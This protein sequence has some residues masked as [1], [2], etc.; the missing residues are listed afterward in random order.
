[1]DKT[2]KFIRRHKKEKTFD[3]IEGCQ[4]DYGDGIGALYLKCDKSVGSIWRLLWASAENDINKICLLSYERS[5]HEANQHQSK[6]DIVREKDWVEGSDFQNRMAKSRAI[7]RVKEA[8][9]LTTKKS[10]VKATIILSDLVSNLTRSP[11]FD[12][13]DILTEE[14]RRKYAAMLTMFDRAST[15]VP[16]AVNGIK[17]TNQS[18]QWMQILTTISALFIPPPNKLSLRMSCDLFGLNRKSKYTKKGLDNRVAYDKYLKLN[19]DVNVGEMVWC[20]GGEGVL[21]AINLKDDSVTI[22]LHPWECDVTYQPSSRARMQR[23]EPNLMEWKKKRRSDIL[24][25]HFIHTI[26]AFHLKHNHPSPNAKDQ[27]CWRHPDYP[28]Q[29][30]YAP[31]IYQYETWDQLWVEF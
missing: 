22:I 23:Y 1:M 13:N 21:K 9:F 5:E 27:L 28:Q 10:T 14:C 8:L 12:E 17:G 15:C 25:T 7:K 24:P 29:K 4:L 30:M 20:R 16:G 3:G 18:S 31:A 26:E 6:V 19:G 11:H 2:I